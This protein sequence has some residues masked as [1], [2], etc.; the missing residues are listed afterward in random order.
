[1]APS[2]A[3]GQHALVGRET[4]IANV[5]DTLLRG[6]RQ[7]VWISGLGGIGKSALARHCFAAAATSVKVQINEDDE[8]ALVDGRLLVS[9]LAAQLRDRGHQ[10]EKFSSALTQFEAVLERLARDDPDAVS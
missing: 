8:E 5:L 4:E 2:A 7:I 3:E 10:L 1:M 9:S 6:D